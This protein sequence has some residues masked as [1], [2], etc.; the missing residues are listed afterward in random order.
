M[1][2]KLKNIPINKSIISITITLLTTLI[3][4][5]CETASSTWAWMCATMGHH[6]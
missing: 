4:I 6:Y 3:I 1:I 5:R 2:L